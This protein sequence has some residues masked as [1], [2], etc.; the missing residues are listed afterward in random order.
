MFYYA[1]KNKNS[2]HIEHPAAPHVFEDLTNFSLY[3]LKFEPLLAEYLF[4]DFLKED[5]KVVHHK[6][7][8]NVNEMKIGFKKHTPKSK[9]K[10]SNKN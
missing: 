4:W 7:R 8:K 10:K 9:Y 6:F 2:G 3:H 1:L 5:K